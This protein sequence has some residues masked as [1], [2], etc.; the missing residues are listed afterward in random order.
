MR[1]GEG[2]NLA[3]IGGV[4]HD[5]LIA[6]HSG[7]ETELGNGGTCGSKA[8]AVKNGSVRKHKASSRFLVR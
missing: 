4:C 7:V 2:D 6:C 1:E 8:V 5:L 3:G